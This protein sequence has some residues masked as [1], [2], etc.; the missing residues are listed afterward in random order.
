MSAPRTRRCSPRSSTT[1][2]ATLADSPEALAY[3][4][5]RKIDD[6]RWS[7]RFRLGYANRTLGYRLPSKQT[8][9]GGAVR[10]R[11]IASGCSAPR[12]MST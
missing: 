9:E 8:K 10:G 11:L 1:T 2:S 4:A 3:L 12:A 5:R 6:P 7:T